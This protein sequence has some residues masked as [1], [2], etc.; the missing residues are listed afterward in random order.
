MQLP[1]ATR[2]RPSHLLHQHPSRRDLA[3]GARTLKRHLPA[4]RADAAPGQ[5]FGLGL[6]ARRAR[7]RRSCASRRRSPSLKSF[8]GG[9]DAYVFTINGFPY[10]SFHGGAVKEQRLRARLVRLPSGSPTRT[11]WPTSLA[12][13]LPDGMRGSI[14]T[15][16]G[17]FSAWAD[18]RVPA[19]ARELRPPCGASRGG[20]RARPARIIAPGARA[21][22]AAASWRRSR[23][24]R[25]SSRRRSIG[26][27]R[28]RAARRADRAVARRGRRCAPPPS[29]R[30]LRRLPCGGGVRGGRGKAWSSSAARAIPS[31]SCS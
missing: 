12:R 29:R 16:P 1:G 4:I 2:A 15:V 24:P 13:L 7:R 17:T 25:A 19:I 9:Q 23:R 21:G 3:G 5:P 6:R 14:S 22:A 20:P 8:F 28:G 18:G 31:P 27:Q 10:G 26:E 11:G 30:L